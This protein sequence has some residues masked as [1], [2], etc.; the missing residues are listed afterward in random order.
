MFNVF[1]IEFVLEGRNEMSV[2]ITFIQGDRVVVSNHVSILNELNLLIMRFYKK[3]IWL[4][5]SRS[6]KQNG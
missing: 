3:H 6:S 4:T 2:E 1:Y 5:A